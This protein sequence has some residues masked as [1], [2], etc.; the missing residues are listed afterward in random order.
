MWKAEKWEPKAWAELFRK[1]G[2]QYVVLTTKH[3]DG[4]CLF[5]SDH[6]DFNSVNM[7]PMTMLF[8]QKVCGWVSIIPD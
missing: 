1:A 5:P 8:V 2:A 4:F 7:G 6:T 3:H